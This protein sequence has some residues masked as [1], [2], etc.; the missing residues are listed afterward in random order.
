MSPTDQPTPPG[1]NTPGPN[2]AGIA[3]GNGV[4]SWFGAGSGN[5]AA[6]DNGASGNGDLSGSARRPDRGPDGY[7]PPQP[8]RSKAWQKAWQ[9]VLVLAAWVLFVV[10]WVMVA[11]DTPISSIAVSAI[12]V[13]A[14]IAAFLLVTLLWIA[15]NLRIYRDKGPRT[16][17]RKVVPDFSHDFVER[18]VVAD[19]EDLRS[20]GLIAVTIDDGSK[21]VLPVSTP[22]NRAAGNGN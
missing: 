11:L 2:P 3:W 14:A 19:W 1:E 8:I 20:S 16:G 21:V 17:V 7:E 22:M 9:V 4:A 12:V 13:G 10:C 15:H 18:P 5:G 6:S